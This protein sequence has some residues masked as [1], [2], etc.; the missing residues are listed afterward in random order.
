MLLAFVSFSW[1]KAY[2]RFKPRMVDAK[3]GILGPTEKG[4]DPRSLVVYLPYGVDVPY[5]L[6]VWR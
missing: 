2:P 4:D 6:D 1:R 3:D 5:L